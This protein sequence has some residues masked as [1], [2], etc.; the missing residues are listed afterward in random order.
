MPEQKTLLQAFKERKRTK[1]NL[2]VQEAKRLVNLYRSLHCFGPEFVEKYNQLLLNS[3]PG[4]RRLFGTFMGGQ[5]V[6]DYFEFLQKNAHDSGQK[7]SGEAFDSGSQIKGYLPEPTE[8]NSNVTSGMP[9]S[10]WQQIKERQELLSKQ[11]QQIMQILGQT[12]KGKGSAMSD[13]YSEI[14][15]ESTTDLGEGK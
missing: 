6:R 14:I 2:D 10:E 11:I 13:D 15:E 9:S 5:E 3:T 8:E 12:P 1:D 7:L 4:V